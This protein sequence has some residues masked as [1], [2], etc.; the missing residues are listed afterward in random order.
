MHI[1]LVIS[2]PVPREPWYRW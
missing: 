1:H 2:G